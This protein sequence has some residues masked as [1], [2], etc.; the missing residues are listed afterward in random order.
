[1]TLSQMAVAPVFPVWLIILILCLGLASAFAQYRATRERLGHAR[2]L[3]ISLLRLGAISLLAAFAL[4]P[5]L[6]AKME[7]RLAPSVA[8]LVDTSQSMG[9]SVSG[10]KG[11][12]LDEARAILMEGAN[13]LLR[14]LRE[15]FDVSIYGLANALRA[16]E[17]GDLAHLTVEGN[18]GN[19]TDALS[20][21]RQKNSAVILLS[22]GNL[23]WNE[24]DTQGL[25]IITV[26]I[27]DPKAYKDVLIKGIKAPS[28]A[29]RG[30]EVT[31]EV[32]VKSHGY[33]GMTLPVL[34][35]DPEK[36]KLLATKD[37]RIQA[38]PGEVTTAVSFV[39]D[40]LGQNNLLISVPQQVGE[41]I[42]TNNQVNLSIEV[43]RDKTRI[44]MVS[45]SPSMNYRFMRMALKNDPSIDLL[46]FV[47][48]RTP[49]DILNVPTQE[50]SLIPFPVESLFIKELTNFDLLIF[51]N[52][53]YSRYLSPHHLE[54]I[55]DF[56]K[57]GGG[58]AMI[59]GP[60]LFHEERYGVSPIGDILPLGFVEKELYRRDSP[61]GVK[62]SRAGTTHP[63]MR[64]S[65]D[66]AGDDPDPQR[67][68]QEV[69]PLDGINLMEA[70]RS[71]TVLLESAG[72]IPWPILTVSDFGK[73]RALALATDYS[74]KWY[75][76]MV[77]EG[78][79]TQAYFRLIHRMVRW[80]T[81][82]PSLDPIQI[83]LPQLAASTGQE[84]EV[85]VQVHAQDLS[86]KSDAPPLF[87]VFNP[88]GGKIESTLKSTAQPGEYL[89][90]FVPGKGGIYRIAIETPAGQRDASMVVAGPLE[91]FDAAPD[92]EQLKKIS[93]STGGVYVSKGEDLPQ[94]IERYAQRGERRF[95]EERRSPMWATPVVLA[96]ILG[97][98]SSEWY[99][100]RR[101]GLV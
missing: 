81:R 11:S 47:I 15:R 39:P 67:F 80:L 26:P 32:T 90:S 8:I 18:K 12:R 55:R 41:N 88:E 46:S 14:S 54:G 51:D 4:N 13:P 92:H 57:G 98:L 7:H 50:Q 49:S 70:K 94:A 85:R 21:L 76:G 42:V 16:L 53:N 25:P 5:S 40:Q 93:Q 35:T 9:Q 77:A 82:D 78:K 22:D 2:A 6:V 73:G 44:L 17:P 71:S 24:G 95:L 101:W 63:M 45:G 29:F 97:L 74:W 83:I 28:L 59:G 79:G 100:R 86:R 84:V 87:S 89:V 10:E 52:F 56:V 65:D 58:F 37:V 69:P 60:S 64:L 91:N 99:C 96:V 75:M 72:G 27:G 68:W 66:P 20:V 43:V 62:L 33:L 19:L 34:L 31:I 48:L 23:G 1:M 61:I 36:R 3:A 30:R 38:E